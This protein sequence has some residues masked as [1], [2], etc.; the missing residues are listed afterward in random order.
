MDD[1]NLLDDSPLLPRLPPPPRAA[2]LPPQQQ[3]NRVLAGTISTI[4]LSDI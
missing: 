2:S 3:D 4:F 1:V